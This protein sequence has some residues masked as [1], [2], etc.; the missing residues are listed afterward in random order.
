MNLTLLFAVSFMAVCVILRY[1]FLELS[2]SIEFQKMFTE[3][4]SSLIIG[5]SKAARLNGHIITKSLNKASKYPE[6]FNYAFDAGTSPY[7]PMYV[8]SIMKKLEK[9]STVKNRIFILAIDPGSV[10]ST[11]SHPEDSSH[12]KENN[13]LLSFD[14]QAKFA[15]LKYFLQF[16]NKSFYTSFLPKT[17]NKATQTPPNNEVNKKQLNANLEAYRKFYAPNATFSKLRY[18]YF[19]QLIDSLQLYGDIY[20]LKLP[21]AVERIKLEHEYNPVFN[22]MLGNTLSKF[23]VHLIDFHPYAD[24]FLCADGVH[25]SPKD[26]MIVSQIV[27]ETIRLNNL[28]LLPFDSRNLLDNYLLYKGSSHDLRHF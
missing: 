18:R 26:A 6:V 28:K 19:E 2:K 20:L 9:N 8:S 14:T 3:R 5:T 16:Y 1:S 23:P 11:I 13:R 17:T 4:Q 24:Q 15:S 12:F 21:M 7:G 27:G 22:Q 10:M 25:L